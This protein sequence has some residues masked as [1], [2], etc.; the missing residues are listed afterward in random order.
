MKR[1]G[2]SGGMGHLVDDEGKLLET[3]ESHA[4]LNSAKWIGQEVCRVHL[5]D[6]YDAEEWN[7][8]ITPKNICFYSD[9]KENCK[10]IPR[11]MIQM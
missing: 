4:A 11:R 6:D 5:S 2:I 9:D 1:A 7:M 8:V 3:G 10:L